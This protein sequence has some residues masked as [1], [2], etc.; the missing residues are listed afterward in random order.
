MP[1]ITDDNVVEAIAMEY[2]ANGMVKCLALEAV[3]YTRQYSRTRGLAVYDNVRV[4]QAI[5]RLQGETK[6]ES[7]ARP[8]SKA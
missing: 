5:A 2:L 4:K 3:G 8:P 6:A 7:V 1:S